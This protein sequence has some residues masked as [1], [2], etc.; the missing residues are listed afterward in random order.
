MEDASDR[1]SLPYERK[2]EIVLKNVKFHFASQVA[3]KS[4]D[5]IHIGEP[6][7]GPEVPVNDSHACES[8]NFVLYGKDCSEQ[9]YEFEEVVE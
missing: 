4:D 7:Q 6:W 2:E 8:E 9:D 3:V 5:D 1:L